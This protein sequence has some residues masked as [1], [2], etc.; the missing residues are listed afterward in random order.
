MKSV[1]IAAFRAT[2]NGFSADRV[3]A[4]PILN[5]AF[6]AKCFEAG[7][8]QTPAALNRALLNLRKQGE[9]KGPRAKQTSFIEEEAYRFAAEMAIRF[10]ERRDKVTLDDVICDPV[11][12]REFDC[13]ASEIAPGFSP[14]QYRWAALN[15]RKSSTLSPEILSRVAPPDSVATFR[16]EGLNVNEIPTGQGLYLFFS[17]LEA[18]YVGESEN[19]R[20]RIAKHI[21]H[22]DNKFFARW[23]WEQTAS[24]LRLEIQVL[25]PDITTRVRKALELELIR[26]RRPQFNVIR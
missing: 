3:V 10:L 20:T 24:Q 5:D 22:S 23:L 18:L 16:V 4:D 25:R 19:L 17:P 21:D 26:S 12:A 7:S 11:R 15:L 8:D 2:C 1:L 9:L 14:L 13:L 6:V